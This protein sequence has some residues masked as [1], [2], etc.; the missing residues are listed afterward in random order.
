MV[1]ENEDG[2]WR[3]LVGEFGKNTTTH[4][5]SNIVSASHKYG[6]LTWISVVIFAFTVLMLQVGLLVRQYFDYNVNVQVR[7]TMCLNITLW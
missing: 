1:N 7:V 5:I 2:S 6:R 4:G 3:N